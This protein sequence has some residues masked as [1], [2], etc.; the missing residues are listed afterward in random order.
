MNG[1]KVNNENLS[2]INRKFEDY[3]NGRKTKENENLA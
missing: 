3:N 2:R 1:Q